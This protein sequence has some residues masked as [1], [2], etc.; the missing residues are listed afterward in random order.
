M[1]H[2]RNTVSPSIGGAPQNIFF[3]TCDAFGVIPPILKL[4]KQQAMY[5]FISGYTS[6]VAGT[7]A[8]VVLPE[9][10]F[11]AC[12][13]SPFMPLDPSAYAE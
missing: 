5:H 7:E 12:F 6:K 3:L 10:V 8:G 11:S 9:P 2:I 13:G 1:E 4:S